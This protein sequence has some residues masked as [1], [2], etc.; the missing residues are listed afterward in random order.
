LHHTSATGSGPR[1]EA[2]GRGYFAPL[3]TAR[4]LLLTT[5]SPDGAQV[6]APVPGLADGDRAY[7]RAWS[8]SGVV[9]CL[10]HT[11]TVQVARCSRLGVVSYG[12]PLHAT[13]R[14]LSGEE[15]ARAAWALARDHPFQE[16]Y[17]I[18]LLRRC[19]WQP[20]HYELVV[21]GPGRPG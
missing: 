13:A 6:S 21:P 8:R 9:R 2:V 15:A 4:Y 20:V 7:F 11:Q 5:F 17:V 16:R 1:Q 12:T 14:P 3:A 18:P 10:R 19:R